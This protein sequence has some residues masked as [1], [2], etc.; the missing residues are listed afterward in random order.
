MSTDLIKQHNLTA[1]CLAAGVVEVNL[2]AGSGFMQLV[3]ERVEKSDVL[4]GRWFNRPGTTPPDLWEESTYKECVKFIFFLPAF[5]LRV[6]FWDGD[7]VTGRPTEV[8]C[9]WYIQ[10]Q[11]LGEWPEITDALS[12]SLRSEALNKPKEEVEAANKSRVDAI[13]NRL[14]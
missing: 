10:L 8:R 11:D 7:L 14:L 5:R 9:D 4:S 12:K 2:Y 6:E 13:Y 3:R 1:T